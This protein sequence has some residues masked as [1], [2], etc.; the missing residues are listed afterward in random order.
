MERKHDKA[1]ADA[2]LAI[3]EM[4]DQKMNGRDERKLNILIEL[5][6]LAEVD[7]AT[8]AGVSRELKR[9][10]YSVDECN[11]AWSYIADS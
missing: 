8:I 5:V 3:D 11:S 2:M 10:G 9:R 7:G 6:R 1:V 4:K